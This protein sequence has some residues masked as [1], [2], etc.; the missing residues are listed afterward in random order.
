MAE[1]QGPWVYWV[2]DEWL[3]RMAG[4]FINFPASKNRKPIALTPSSSVELDLCIEHLSYYNRLLSLFITVFLCQL[5]TVV[6]NVV[7]SIDF[8]LIYLRIYSLAD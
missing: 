7:E 6:C 4:P 2:L 3:Q 1:S 8:L 5:L